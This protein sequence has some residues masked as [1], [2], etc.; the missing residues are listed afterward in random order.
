MAKPLFKNQTE[1]TEDL[2]KNVAGYNFFHGKLGT[3]GSLFVAYALFT[4]SY[5]L[6]D[7]ATKTQGWIFMILALIVLPIIFFVVPYFITRNG[8]KSS[9]TITVVTTEIYEDCI[10]CKNNTDVSKKYYYNQMKYVRK[11]N[12]MISILIKDINQPL[13]MN[14]DSFIDCTWQEAYEFLSEKINY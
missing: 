6:E 11:D 5:K 8:Y 3:I 1:Y 10:V 7:E 12:N 2:Y 9:K 4:A 14:K 13:F